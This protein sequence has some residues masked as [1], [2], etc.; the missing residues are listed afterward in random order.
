MNT[1]PSQDWCISLTPRK[2][3][4][5][6]PGLNWRR[7]IR[8]AATAVCR[9]V[10]DGARLGYG[11]AAP[12]SDV[13]IKDIAA[14]CDIFSIGGTKVGAMFGEAIVIV[15]DSLKKDFRY[16]IKQRGGMLA[17]GRLLGVQ[18]A[19]MFE[20]GLY[21]EMSRHAVSLAM[22]IRDAFAARGIAFRYDSPTNQQFPILHDRSLEALGRSYSFLPWERM[23]ESHC[24]VRFCTSWATRSEHV[25]QLIR[26]IES[27]PMA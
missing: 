24:A 17:K 9:S 13:T 4:P 7:C 18:F 6:T 5:F 25:E 2:T 10:L 21:H 3:V 16:L 26:D 8:S 27:M 11:V 23:D 22:R 12:G 20:D 14:L 15:N 1:W 19:A